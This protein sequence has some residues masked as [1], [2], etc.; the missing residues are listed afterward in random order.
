[1]GASTFR[2]A[3]QFWD[4]GVI[5]IVQSYA[6]FLA[7][8][9]LNALHLDSHCLYIQRMHMSPVT[10]KVFKS[11]NSQAIRLPKALRLKSKT[12]QIEKT[13]SGLL[14]LDPQAEAARLKAFS[15][16]YGSCPDFPEIERLLLS[17]E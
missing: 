1:V 17:G 8:S 10:A 3:A 7:A 6:L 13:G 15:K 11:G 12:V 16:L 5:S 4:V 2:P 14:I 9:V